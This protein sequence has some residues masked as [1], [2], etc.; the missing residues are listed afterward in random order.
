LGLQDRI[1]AIKKE[2]VNVFTTVDKDPE[3]KKDDSQETKAPENEEQP[4]DIDR[5][6]NPDE[7]NRFLDGDPDRFKPKF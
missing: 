2:D 4:K 3:T 1:N 6:A 7:N 5:F